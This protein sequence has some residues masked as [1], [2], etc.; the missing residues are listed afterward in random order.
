MGRRKSESTGGLSNLSVCTVSGCGKRHL[1]RG[2]CQ[3]HYHRQ[4]RGVPLGGVPPRPELCSVDGCAKRRKSRGYC[5]MHYYRVR[6]SGKPPIP[7]KEKPEFSRLHWDRAGYAITKVAGHPLAMK[8]GGIRVH[9]LKVYA[10]LGA[11]PH[12]CAICGA[13]RSWRAA[14][15]D[16]IDANPENNSD[17]NLRFTCPACN[18]ARGRAKVKATHRAKGRQVTAFGRTRSIHE[19]AEELNIDV[20]S[21][22]W[23]VDNGWDV[24]KAVSAPRGAHGPKKI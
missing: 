8:D 18:Q 5:E 11:G 14:H 2:F 17:E 16:H 23:R 12:P 7:E 15:I 10:R 4:H 3:T 24:E 21:L 13:E 1:A 9:R 19:W 20:V 6:R 22:K